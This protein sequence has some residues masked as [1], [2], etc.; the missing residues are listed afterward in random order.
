MQ[1]PSLMEVKKTTVTLMKP[2]YLGHSFELLTVTLQYRENSRVPA[3]VVAYLQWKH[4][5]NH[6]V[7]NNSPHHTFQVGA[8]CFTGNICASL[9]G[10]AQP[11]EPVLMLKRIHT[12]DGNMSA[13]RIDGSSHTN[14]RHFYSCLFILPAKVDTFKDDVSQQPRLKTQARSEDDSCAGNW[15]AANSVKEDKIQVFDQTGIFLMACQHGFVESVAEVK[16]SGELLLDVCGDGQG[17]GH[18]IGC[19]SRKTV[20]SSSIGEKAKRLGLTIT[21]LN[22]PLYLKGFG[23]EDMETCEKVFASSNTLAPIIQHALY[24]HWAQSLDLHFDQWNVDKYLE[25]KK[26]QTLHNIS[27]ADFVRWNLEELAFLGNLST[28][29]EYDMMT[30]TYVDELD[31]LQQLEAK[32]NKITSSSFL[33][34]MPSH[35]GSDSGLSQ[36]AQLGSPAAKDKAKSLY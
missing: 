6:S 33:T 20:A 35:F 24:F 34:Y 16:H 32:T 29:F 2:K 19:T 14:S 11:N 31:K 9:S 13:R 28:E 15:L 7:S 17:V 8:V 22:H 30:V 36:P 18:N 5:T 1:N 21:L 27:D 12:I 4:G 10:T 23:L 26:F 25:L 3:L